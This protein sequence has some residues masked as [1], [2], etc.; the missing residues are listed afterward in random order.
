MNFEITHIP[1]SE[2]M[3]LADLAIQMQKE[4]P[5]ELSE[6]GTIYTISNI[7]VNQPQHMSLGLYIDK[8]LKGFVLGYPVT[9]D[10]FYF[11]SIYIKKGYRAKHTKRL[12]DK[13][14]ETI[15]NLGF[16]NWIAECY[17]KN[18]ISI[19]HKYQGKVTAVRV[20]KNGLC[21]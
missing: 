2:F 12:I 8:K 14:F 18:I 15:K 21:N 13:S 5:G 11:S 20:T 9:G 1:Y 6:L 17:N 4:M 7:L 16:S 3:N 19:L 10:T